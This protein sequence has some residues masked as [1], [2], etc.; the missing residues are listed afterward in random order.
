MAVD[1]RCVGVVCPILVQQ[2]GESKESARS[3]GDGKERKGILFAEG[4]SI[5]RTGIDECLLAL[6]RSTFTCERQYSS[7]AAAHLVLKVV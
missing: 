5:G 1:T 3:Q 4:R 2:I 7:Q 6:S